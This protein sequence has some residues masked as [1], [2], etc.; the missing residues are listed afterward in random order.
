MLPASP[1][2][3]R[4]RL[5]KLPEQAIREIHPLRRGK[6]RCFPA[7]PWGPTTALKRARIEFSAGAELGGGT[8][9]D[10]VSDVI[11][12]IDTNVLLHY[13]RLEQI[14]W[15]ALTQAQSVLIVL[16]PVVFRELNTI[17]AS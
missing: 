10:A 1:Q 13:Q 15:P 11:L 7:R 8:T 3:T 5:A 17:F 14:D 9:E 2:L 16:P 6:R 4:G 12:F